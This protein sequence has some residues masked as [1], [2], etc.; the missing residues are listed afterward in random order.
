MNTK[1][2]LQIL[3]SAF[4][5]KEPER[6]PVIYPGGLSWG[7]AEVWNQSLTTRADRE[8]IPRDYV[9][10]SEIGGSMIDRYLKMSGVQYSNAPNNRSLRKF[11]AGDIWEWICALVLR[12]AGILIDSQVKLSHQYPGLLRVSGKLDFMAGGKPDWKRARRD[13]AFLGLPE[14]LYNASL[15]I[16]NQLESQ[17]SDD[18]LKSI[19]LEIKSVSSFMYEK[20]DAIQQPGKHH[21][22]QTFHYLKSQGLDEGHIVYVCRD[23]CQLLEF[24]VFNP[25]S[26]ESEYIEDLTEITNYVVTK[27]R[28]PLESEILLDESRFRFEKN[29]KIEYSNYLTMLYGYKTPMEYREKVDKFISD[30]N[31]V[32]KRC[33]TGAKMTDLNLKVIE[34]AK[35]VFPQWDDLVDRARE[36]A[37]RNPKIVELGEEAA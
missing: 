5:W 29:W 35:R 7:F 36:A 25:S 2:L 28:P 12:R 30:M 11:Q 10:A 9:W 22:C 26:V 14:M 19:V 34:N 24:G 27:T 17:F 32:L 23:D 8:L 18:V 37:K 16:I 4:G 1:R 6:Q 20:Y 3:K 15:S 31:R 21:R 33:V 13:L